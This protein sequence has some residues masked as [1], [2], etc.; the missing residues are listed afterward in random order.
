MVE[1]LTL[2]RVLEGAIKK[3]M[4]A[5]R[6]YLD[7]SQR[8]KDSAAR[9]ALEGLAAEEKVHQD[10]LERYRDGKI[11]GALSKDQLVDYH[12]AELVEGPE[13]SANMQLKDAFLYA[14][15]R[16]KASHELYTTLAIIHPEGEVKSLLRQLAGQELEHKQRV[17]SLYTQV[18]FPQ[19]DGG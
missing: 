17:E 16:E 5:Q 9:D 4:E 12:I 10:K 2:D 13:M 14:A 6:L 3:E 8:V 7:L 18:A 1:R 11:K 15:N 19:T